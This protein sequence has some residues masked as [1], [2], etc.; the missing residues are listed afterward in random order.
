MWPERKKGQC[1]NLHSTD[2][3]QP[4]G[5]TENRMP[6]CICDTCLWTGRYCAGVKCTCRKTFRPQHTHPQRT[7]AQSTKPTNPQIHKPRRTQTHKALVRPLTRAT[8]ISRMR[9]GCGEQRNALTQDG[10]RLC[11]ESC[12]TIC[13]GTVQVHLQSKNLIRPAR[14]PSVTTNRVAFQTLHCTCHRLFHLFSRGRSG[15]VVRRVGNEERSYGLPEAASGEWAAC[16]M[17]TS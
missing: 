1:R 9:L 17:A 15:K 10:F 6:W 12:T 11:C 14:K 16:G 2:Y 7:K 8:C 3:A 4:C 13:G 5:N